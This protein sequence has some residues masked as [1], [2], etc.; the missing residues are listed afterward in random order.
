M[1]GESDQKLLQKLEE[2]ESSIEEESARS[3]YQE[4]RFEFE[5]ITRQQRVG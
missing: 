1:F 2:V 3:A 4:K 5:Q